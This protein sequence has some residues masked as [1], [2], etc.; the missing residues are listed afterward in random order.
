M[1]EGRDS[2]LIVRGIKKFLFFRLACYFLLNG[3][4]IMCNVRGGQDE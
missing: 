1:W 2:D 3:V 4:V